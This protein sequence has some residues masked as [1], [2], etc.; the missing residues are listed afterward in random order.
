MAIRTPPRLWERHLQLRHIFVT[1]EGNP[2]PEA[3]APHPRRQAA[4]CLDLPHL[5]GPCKW[6]RKMRALLR[7]AFPTEPR[8]F[9]IPV[10]VESAL[11]PFC[12]WTVC[13]GDGQYRSLFLHL[14]GAGPWVVF[15]FRLLGTV[16]LE[17]S[18]P[19][20][21]VSGACRAPGHTLGA[22]LLVLL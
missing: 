19:S 20:W 17:H 1:P 10:P 8:V 14:S 16:P 9:K 4:V 12:G 18:C 6:N 15:P 2:A 3:V 5:D 21:C 22:E 11:V 7:L 13:H